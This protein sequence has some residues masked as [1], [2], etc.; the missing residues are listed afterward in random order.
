VMITAKTTLGLLALA[1]AAQNW[2]LRRNT[3]IERALL[4]ASGLLLVFPGLI[5]AIVEA[6]IGR[7]ISYTFV[8]GVLIGVGV[9]AW[10]LWTPAQQK[11]AATT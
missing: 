8:P 2:A 10:Q 11:P 5:E 1:A 9:L 6:V 7:D 3:A 4:I